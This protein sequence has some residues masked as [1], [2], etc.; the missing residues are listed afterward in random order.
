[1]SPKDMN[2]QDKSVLLPRQIRMTKTFKI[3]F[4]L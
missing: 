2:Y 3:C 1:M 4:I